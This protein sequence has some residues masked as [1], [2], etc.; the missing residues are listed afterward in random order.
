MWPLGARPDLSPEDKEVKRKLVSCAMK[1]S[2][3]DRCEACPTSFPEVFS[4]LRHAAFHPQIFLTVCFGAPYFEAY[5]GRAPMPPGGAG[6][7]EEEREM[8]TSEL[9]RG[10][11][12]YSGQDPKGGDLSPAFVCHRGW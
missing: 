12:S 8:E 2:F 7:E 1:R 11:P 6:K 10:L 5:M 4:P 9:A 3:P